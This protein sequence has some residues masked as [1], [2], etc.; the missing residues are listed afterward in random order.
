[1]Q[2]YGVKDRKEPTGRETR[3]CSKRSTHQLA[4][5]LTA[6]SEYVVDAEMCEQ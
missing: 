1:V 4:E 5:E 6:I 2:H 3:R